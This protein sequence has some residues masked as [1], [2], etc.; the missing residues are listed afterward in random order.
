MKLNIVLENLSYFPQYLDYMY[1]WR[2]HV[3]ADNQ[4]KSDIE[5]TINDKA[6]SGANNVLISYMPNEPFNDQDYQ[7]ILFDNE[8]EPVSICMT[9]TMLDYI[10]DPRVYY[11]GNSIVHDS[12]QYADKIIPYAHLMH[13]MKDYHTRP[14]YPQYYFENNNTREGIAYINGYNRA[15]RQYIKTKILDN[16][17][18]NDHSKMFKDQPASKLHDSM[19]ESKEDQVFRDTVNNMYDLQNSKNSYYDNSINIGHDNKFGQINPGYF[20]FDDIKDKKILMFPESNWINDEISITG[21]K[22]C[23]CFL[24]H[25]LPLPIAGSNTN[26]LYNDLGFYTAWNLL[27][28]ALRDYDAMPNHMERIDYMIHAIRWLSD[29]INDIDTTK[30]CEMNYVNYIKTKVPLITAKRLH[31]VLVETFGQY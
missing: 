12:F 20:M 22:I 3:N 18:I 26:K 10:S 28:D 1:A 31:Q 8:S 17:N 27:P 24:H 14:M 4:Y 7:L 15:N 25:I 11:V 19:I 21:D 6:V 9:P 13:V 30:L 23:K 5:Y 2:Q 29:N 16:C